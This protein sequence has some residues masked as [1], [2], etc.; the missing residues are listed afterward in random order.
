RS[1]ERQ[2]RFPVD[3]ENFLGMDVLLT[4]P[5]IQEEAHHTMKEGLARHRGAC[6]TAVALAAVLLP[7]RIATA[8]QWGVTPI[9]RLSAGPAFHVEPGEKA[10]TQLA[11]DVRAGAGVGGE[12]LY[13]SSLQL[14]S[15]LG[16]SYD[17]F[18]SHLFTFSA[19]VGYGSFAAAWIYHPRFLVGT[20]GGHAVVGMRN[21]LGLH[22][23]NDIYSLEVGHQLLASGGSFQHDVRILLGLNPLGLLRFTLR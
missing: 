16:Y 13:S 20:E 10:V 11:F 18:G 17:H 19:G 2:A 23:F 21:S 6:L 5:R 15:E 9:L 3:T 7:P 14:M 1:A 12:S 8:T 22:L 4:S